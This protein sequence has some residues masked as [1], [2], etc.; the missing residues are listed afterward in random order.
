MMHSWFWS[1]F[2]SLRIVHTFSTAGSQENEQTKSDANESGPVLLARTVL[3][4]C[5]V[6]FSVFDFTPCLGKNNVG[7]KQTVS[8]PSSILSGIACVSV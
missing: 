7:F 4:S 8:V 2:E 5:S 6:G 3:I 1:L